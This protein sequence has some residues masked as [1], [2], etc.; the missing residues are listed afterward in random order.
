MASIRFHAAH[1][2]VEEDGVDPLVEKEQPRPHD[3]GQALEA[4]PLPR[5]GRCRPGG[6]R[7]L[8]LSP[9]MLCCLYG[10]D[11]LS[12]RLPVAS[13]EVAPILAAFS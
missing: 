1:R 6:E 10:H 4:P 8:G 3:R 12:F 11:R 2:D 13:L 7:R 5:P 9:A